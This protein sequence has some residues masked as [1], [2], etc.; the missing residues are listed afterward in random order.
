MQEIPVMEE[1][2]AAA[3]NLYPHPRAVRCAEDRRQPRRTRYVRQTSHSVSEGRSSQSL[4]FSALVDRSTPSSHGPRVRES[5]VGALFRPRTRYDAREFRAARRAADPSGAS[6]LARSRLHRPRLGHQTALPHNRPIGHLSPR[7]SLFA[8]IARTRSGESIAGPRPQP[9]FVGRTNSRCRTRRFRIARSEN[10][11][12]AR[13]AVS[14][15]RRSMARGQHDV[16]AYQ[17]S[18][19]RDLYRRSLYSVWKRTTPLPNMMAFD[20][21][22]REVCTVSRGRTNTPLQALVLLNDVQFVEA[23]RALAADVSSRTQN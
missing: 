19:G 13:L 8:R 1:M 23:A 20:A 21:P 5:N 7:F 14:T 15:R 10:G 6:R 3:T 12:P 18:T 17:Q 11:R 4:G 2:P 9:S 22:S 16:A